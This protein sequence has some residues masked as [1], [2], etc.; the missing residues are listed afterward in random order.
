[1]QA[2]WRVVVTVEICVGGGTI[3]VGDRSGG[4]TVAELL[5][6]TGIVQE[7]SSMEISIKE[8]TKG[9]NTRYLVEQE[10]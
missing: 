7:N 9:C 5:N 2:H 8:T 4:Y 3:R 1:M 10:Y 6:D